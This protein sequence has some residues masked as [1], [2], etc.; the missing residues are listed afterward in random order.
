M[1]RQDI[2]AVQASFNRVLPMRDEF[3]T[4]FYGRLFEIAPSVRPMF[5]SDTT[6]LRAK[7]VDTLDYVLLHLYNLD[8]LKSAVAELAQ[9]HVDYGTLPDHFAPTGA[10][11]IHAL[12]VHSKDG[13][14]EAEQAAWLAVYTFI[15]DTMIEAMENAKA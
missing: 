4:T 11:L 5:P 7:L 12:D 15:S 2:K 14:T 6:E 9:K 8:G 3:S 13:L 10:A 1:Q